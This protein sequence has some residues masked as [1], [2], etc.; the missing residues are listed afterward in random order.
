[1]YLI[2][3]LLLGNVRSVLS[4]R[5]SAE[6]ASK[7]NKRTQDPHCEKERRDGRDMLR[8]TQNLTLERDKL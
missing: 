6:K 3:M 2:I 4:E 1:M 7:K 8:V 5:A